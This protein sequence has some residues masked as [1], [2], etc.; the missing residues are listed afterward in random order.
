MIDFLAGDELAVVEAEAIVQQQLNVGNNQFAG[1]LVNGAVQFLLYHGEHTPKD[2]HFRGRE[3]QRL[4]AGIAEKLIAAHLSAQ[5]G[6]IEKVG[7]E[8]QGCELGKGHLGVGLHPYHL[9]R[10]KTRHGHL[11]NVVRCSAVREF[12]PLVLLEVDG[13]KSIVHHA[14]RDVLRILHMHHADQGMKRLHPLIVVEV[15]Y[16]IKKN[17]LHIIFA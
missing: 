6:A 11:V 15:L 1:V 5:G 12:A 13:I 14:L 17:L 9:P 8:N 10:R 4:V 16:G 7:M 2:F 3:M